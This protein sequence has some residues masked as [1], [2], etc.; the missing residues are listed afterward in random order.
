VPKATQ[1]AAA[2]QQQ[3]Y[4]SEEQRFHEAYKQAYTMSQL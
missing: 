2:Q 3:Q 1:A 4:A